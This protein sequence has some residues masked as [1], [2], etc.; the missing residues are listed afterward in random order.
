MA[1]ADPP[2]LCT[3]PRTV[4][5]EGQTVSEAPRVLIVEDLTDGTGRLATMLAEAGFL[6]RLAAN[7]EYALD[8]LD[9]WQPAAVVVDLRVEQRAGRR[10]CTALGQRSDRQQRPVVLIGEAPNLLKRMPVVPSGLVSAP[11]EDEQLVVA[12]RRVATHSARD[13]ATVN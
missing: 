4:R 12:V 2:I 8:Y 5:K 11:F 1:T 7:D 6:T 13:L 10:F 3:V 9:G